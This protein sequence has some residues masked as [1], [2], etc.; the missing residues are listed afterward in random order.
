M[1]C[2]CINILPTKFNT[3]LQQ[4]IHQDDLMNIVLSYMCRATPFHNI[5][6]SGSPPMMMI[7]CLAY[8]ECVT[9]QKGENALE[10]AVRGGGGV[11]G[12]GRV[13][14]APNFNF[15]GKFTMPLMNI[16]TD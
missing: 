2:I 6:S 11:A 5:A 14:G 8:C 15:W 16:N 1:D 7:I 13:V 10:V 4:P 9:S 3:H 12:E